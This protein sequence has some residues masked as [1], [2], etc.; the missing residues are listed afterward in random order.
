MKLT[1]QKNSGL[2]LAKIAIKKKLIIVCKELMWE[3]QLEKEDSLCAISAF[4][5]GT[6]SVGSV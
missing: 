1:V 5:Y 3:G 4:I 2:K 6:V